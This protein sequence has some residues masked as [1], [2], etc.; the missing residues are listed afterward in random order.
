MRPRKAT[1]CVLDQD[2][3][4]VLVD[5]F[6]VFAVELAAR[7]GVGVRVMVRVRVSVSVWVWVGFGFRVA[8]GLGFGIV[9]GFRAY[10]SLMLG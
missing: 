8:F 6:D 4:G 5:D 9:K 3:P 1:L 7:V 10:S 2:V